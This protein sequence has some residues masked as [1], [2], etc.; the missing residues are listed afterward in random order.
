ME[1]AYYRRTAWERRQQALVMI[2]VYAE[3]LARAREPQHA[4]LPEILDTLRRAR[5]ETGAPWV[6]IR[7][8]DGPDA[9]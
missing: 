8:T 9:G 2:N 3:A 7:Q 6:E 1:R 4:P 5:T